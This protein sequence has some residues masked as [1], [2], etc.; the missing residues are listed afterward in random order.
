M[1]GIISYFRV[2]NGDKE[3]GIPAHRLLLSLRSPVF[4]AMFH[5]S[6]AETGGEVEVKD[7]EAA[8][9]HELIR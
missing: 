1:E 8:A 5:G 2:R 3:E 6:L 4:F 7:V 9:F